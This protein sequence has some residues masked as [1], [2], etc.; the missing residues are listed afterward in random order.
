MKIEAIKTDANGY[1]LI[2]ASKVLHF[3]KCKPQ[4]YPC[5]FFDYDPCNKTLRK[6]YGNN[7]LSMPM[8][9]FK[10]AIKFIFAL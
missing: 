6:F 7:H 5:I 4:V 3:P 10:D 9:S 2:A 1:K 8:E